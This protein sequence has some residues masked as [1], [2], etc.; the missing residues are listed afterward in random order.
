MSSYGR[1]A[2]TYCYETVGEKQLGAVRL[3]DPCIMHFLACMGSSWVFEAFAQKNKL[4][5][6]PIIR[7]PNGGDASR[8]TPTRVTRSSLVGGTISSLSGPNL[9]E[10]PVA[11]FTHDLCG[12]HGKNDRILRSALSSVVLA[13]KWPLGEDCR[14]T[15]AF[16]PR[17]SGG[18][19]HIFRYAG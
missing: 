7:D 14:S 17:S 5:E 16:V 19:G 15:K 4:R 10:C 8:A 9:G 11:E 13:R 18:G 6:R 12:R 2:A 1:G 3:V